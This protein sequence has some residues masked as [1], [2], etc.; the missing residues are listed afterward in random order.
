MGKAI[1]GIREKEKKKGSSRRHTMVKYL[2]RLRK[3]LC[4][5]IDRSSVISLGSNRAYSTALAT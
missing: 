1:K 5:F 2:L 3:T 4:L